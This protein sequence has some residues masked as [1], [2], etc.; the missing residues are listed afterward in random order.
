[1]I[2]E[3]K[4]KVD[5]VLSLL[6]Q[7]GSVV[8]PKNS[9][10]IL[11]NIVIESIDEHA[12]LITASDG[13]TWVSGKLMNCESVSSNTKFSVSAKN[14][15]QALSRLNGEDVTIKVLEQENQIECTYSNGQFKLPYQDAS[16]YP[17]PPQICNTNNPILVTLNV[18]ADNLRT[19]IDLTKFA[20][21]NDMLRPVMNGI[22]FDMFSDKL[23]LVAS[24][25]HKLVKYQDDTIKCFEQEPNATNF[26][27]STKPATILVKMLQDINPS[28]SRIELNA[29]TT[30]IKISNGC[31]T[32]TTRLTEG[33]YPNYNAVIPIDNNINAIFARN[34]AINA[35]K[36]ILPFGNTTSNCVRLE[37]TNDNLC[38]SCDDVDFATSA[39]EN[40]HCTYQGEPF[41]IGF[42]GLQLIQV[43]QN[44]GDNNVKAFMSRPEK[45]AMFTPETQL[46][47][48][49]YTSILMPTLLS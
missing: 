7:V 32:M 8:S 40:I 46:H 33:R 21:A 30:N 37:F 1:M 20:T 15:I 41:V 6:T 10:P 25:G 45:A 34:D 36:R 18:E 9:L 35:L 27:I 38:I 14:F 29:T 3:I 2:M 31:F 11:D 49:T 16:Q 42:N 23:V 26:I 12:T 47:S 28:Y 19:A 13:E 4:L 39:K 22:D 48:F 5:E 24:D 17:L 44:I 43:L